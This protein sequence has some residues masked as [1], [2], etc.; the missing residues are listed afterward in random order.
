MTQGPFRLLHVGCGPK[1][2]ANLPPPFNQSP[3]EEIRLDIDPAVRPDIAASITDMRAVGDG[4]V[5]ALWSAHN[6]EHLHP[7]EVPLALAEFARV[8]VADGFAMITVPDLQMV[9]EMVARGALTDTAYVSPAGPIAPIDMLY[10][11]RPAL[12]AGNLYMAHRTGFTAGS[13][14]AA[15]L[16]AGFAASAVRRDGNWALWAV[17]SRNGKDAAPVAQ[18]ADSLARRAAPAAA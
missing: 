16:E 12:A 6:I 2:R 18:L 3:W 8:L 5:H 13:L 14:D 15:L 7:H 1:T 17:A 4:A 9:A 10:G 11:F